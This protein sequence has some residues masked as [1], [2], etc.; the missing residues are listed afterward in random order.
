MTDLTYLM[1]G[2]KLNSTELEFVA[3]CLI[4]DFNNHGFSIACSHYITHLKE[5][6]SDKCTYIQHLESN[7]FECAIEFGADYEM[8]KSYLMQFTVT[9]EGEQTEIIPVCKTVY[10]RLCDE[11]VKLDL[12]AWDNL[13]EMQAEA[14]QEIFELETRLPF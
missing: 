5:V 10:M 8:Y 11:L 14:A 1:H 12:E 13:D 6:F 9:T 7:A 4:T 2:V 3:D